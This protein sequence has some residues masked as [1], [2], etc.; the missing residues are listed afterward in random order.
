MIEGSSFSGLLT[1]GEIGRQHGYAENGLI[2]SLR[3]VQRNGYR[4][5]STK[6]DRVR[7]MEQVARSVAML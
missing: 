2:R 6:R 7:T 5:S 3:I 4:A 1:R